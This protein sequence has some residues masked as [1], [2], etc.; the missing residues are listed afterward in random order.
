MHLSPP[1]L[2]PRTTCHDIANKGRAEGAY[3]KYVFDHYDVLEGKQIVFSGSTVS[4][5]MRAN[6]VRRVLSK[7]RSWHMAA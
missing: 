5:E 7:G 4:N 1:R 3:F 2:P 6:I